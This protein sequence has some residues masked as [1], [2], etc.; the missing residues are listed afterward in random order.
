VC[1]QVKVSAGGQLESPHP[2]FV[3][4]AGSLRPGRRR[5]RCQYRGLHATTAQS[6]A[7]RLSVVSPTLSRV[8]RVAGTGR[9]ELDD[10]RVATRVLGPAVRRAYSALCACTY[11]CQRRPECLAR[12]CMNGGWPCD[13]MASRECHWD[14]PV[15]LCYR[16]QAGAVDRVVDR[17]S[18]TFCAPGAFRDACAA[19]CAGSEPGALCRASRNA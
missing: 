18:G 8:D 10:P 15:A 3:V 14:L 19:I 17:E 9:A 5:W 12:P 2:S 13:S 16:G 4:S 11:L 1:G 7:H 6:Q